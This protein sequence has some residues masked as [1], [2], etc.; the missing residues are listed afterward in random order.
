MKIKDEGEVAF[1]KKMDELINHTSLHEEDRLLC[2][3]VKQ[4]IKRGE[5]WG[6]VLLDFLIQLTFQS[7]GMKISP[8]MRDIYSKLYNNRSA[9]EN[10]H[11]DT[12][13]SM[14]LLIIFD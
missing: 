13:G 14:T 1:Y 7:M 4:R 10:L 5:D 11:H 2:K 12:E 8:E 3:K 6:E 9:L